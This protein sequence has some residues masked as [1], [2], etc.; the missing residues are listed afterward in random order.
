MHQKNIHRKA[1][2]SRWLVWRG[3]K[4]PLQGETGLSGN[5]RAKSGI[6]TGKKLCRMQQLLCE[7]LWFSVLRNSHTRFQARYCL[8][9]Q[10]SSVLR[11]RT[12][13]IWQNTIVSSIAL[14]RQAKQPV[15]ISCGGCELI[16]DA[17]CPAGGPSFLGSVSVR[18]H[19]SQR[20]ES[21]RSLTWKEVSKG[22]EGDR[23][24]GR[25]LGKEQ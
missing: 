4:C 15:S 1:W 19:K 24:A 12:I 10:V 9:R 21:P 20:C 3:W 22:N 6:F 7:L 2:W 14:N 17:H 11:F 8:R 23:S 13:A 25:G 5:W 18:G 16:W